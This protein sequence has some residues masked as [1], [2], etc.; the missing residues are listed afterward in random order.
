[1][2]DWGGYVKGGGL[3][4]GLRLGLGIVAGNF[5]IARSTVV[6]VAAPRTI[7]VSLCMVNGCRRRAHRD[8]ALIPMPHAAQGVVLAGLGWRSV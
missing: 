3:A 6:A 5:D 7:A 4:W 8:R 1:M 2:C